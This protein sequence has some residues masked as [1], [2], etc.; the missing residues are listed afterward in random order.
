[1]PPAGDARKA[2]DFAALQREIDEKIEA[3]KLEAAEAERRVQIR[4]EYQR[5]PKLVRHHST[6][7]CQ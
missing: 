3:A 7:D 1:V 4:A 2:V 6:A 5:G